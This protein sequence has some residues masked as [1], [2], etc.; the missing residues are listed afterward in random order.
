MINMRN[1][2][3]SHAKQNIGEAQK[4]QR[5][6]YAKRN[7]T[8]YIFKE[9]DKVLVKNLRRDDRKG[10]WKYVPWEGPYTIV[11]INKGNTCTLKSKHKILA[12]KQH[13][14]NLKYF[15]ESSNTNEVDLKN[16]VVKKLRGENDENMNEEVNEDFNRGLFTKLN[17]LKVEEVRKITLKGL[18]NIMEG[19]LDEDKEKQIINDMVDND[20]D[21]VCTSLSV[22]DKRRRVFNPIAKPWKILKC[23]QLKLNLTKVLTF[24][25][26]GKFLSEPAA[27]KKIKG[28]GNC[29]YRALSYWITGIEDNHMEIRKRIAEVVKTNKNIHNYIGGDDDISIYLEKNKIDNDGVW[30]TDVEIFAAAQ[31][32]KTSI[33]VYATTT[34]TW[35]LFNKNLNLKKYIYHTERC[36]Y[37]RNI[38]NVHFDVVL[39]VV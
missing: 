23:A 24:K 26:R 39:G 10:G 33:Y 11:S 34:N 35:Q 7:N 18:T 1:V 38:G 19:E 8:G 20:D 36:I 28:D 17:T 21:V 29:L 9:N 2:M 30:G 13:L 27:T 6:S 31:L 16:N 15:K 22:V 4:R 5:L 14:S 3:E 32:L 12:K 37:I 25:G